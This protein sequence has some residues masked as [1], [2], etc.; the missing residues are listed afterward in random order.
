MM[1]TVDWSQLGW[2]YQTVLWAV[3][4]VALVWGLLRV[5]WMTRL[6]RGHALTL[7]H[8]MDE[9]AGR[10]DRERAKQAEIQRQLE[11]QRAKCARYFDNIDSACKERDGWRDLYQ[12]NASEHSAAQSYLLRTLERIVMRYHKDTGG[13]RIELDPGLRLI[14]A[15]FSER[16]PGVLDQTV[17]R[18][19]PRGIRKV[20]SE[21]TAPVDEPNGERSVEPQ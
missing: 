21:T 19:P 13:K 6:I 11:E 9:S 8:V 3:V 10:L 15:E 18:K 2:N 1:V 16:H 20:P 14:V 4:V 12:Q 7:R 17:P 5:V